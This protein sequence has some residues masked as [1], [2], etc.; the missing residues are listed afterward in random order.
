MSD[1]PVWRVRRLERKRPRSRPVPAPDAVGRTFMPWAAENGGLAEL[2]ARSM[3]GEPPPRLKTP[4]ENEAELRAAGQWPAEPAAA[5]PPAPEAPSP[6]AE[7]RPREYWEE[8][9]RWR[10]RGSR[11]YDDWDDRQRTG[12]RCLTEYDPLSRELYTPREWKE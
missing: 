10:R 9:C 12:N 8:K 6:P 7:E 3:A 2:V 4:E 11:D 1:V 5:P